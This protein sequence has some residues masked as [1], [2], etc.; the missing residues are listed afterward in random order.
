MK[1]TIIVFLSLILIGGTVWF[2][3]D[4][5]PEDLEK[6]TEETTTE[7]I[8]PTEEELEKDISPEIDFPAEEE[9]E[10][11]TSD[12]EDQVIPLVPEDE[13]LDQGLPKQEECLT[14]EDC[15]PI[16]TCVD[17]LCIIPTSDI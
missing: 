15:D 6:P 11:S 7:I 12:Q 14:D 17:G 4:S 10:G 5:R 3:S 9:I 8:A 2:L 16:Y 1:K 13:I